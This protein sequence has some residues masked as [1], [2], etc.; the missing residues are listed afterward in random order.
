MGAL[1]GTDLDTSSP[2]FAALTDDGAILRQWVVLQLATETGSY[3]SSPETGKD[4]AAFVGQGLT[5]LQLAAIPGQIE[6]ALEDQR[7]ASVDVSVSPTFT[8][9]GQAALKITVAVTPKD[10]SLAPFSLT[11]I[12]TRDVANAVTRGL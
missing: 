4:V 1:Y 8:A 7:V 9:T 6:A 2:T 10:A 3:W 5:D 12:A 11:A